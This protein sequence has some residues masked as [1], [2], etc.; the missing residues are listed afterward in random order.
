[1]LNLLLVPVVFFALAFIGLAIRLFVIRFG[2]YRRFCDNID[3]ETGQ[4]IGCTCGGHRTTP[5]QNL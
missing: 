1:M 4:K 5:C 2:R 3:L